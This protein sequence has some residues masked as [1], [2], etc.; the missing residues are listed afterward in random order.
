MSYGNCYFVD[1]VGYVC[2]KNRFFDKSLSDNYGKNSCS[3]FSLV[4]LVMNPEKST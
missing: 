3:K 2:P 1:M 4:N